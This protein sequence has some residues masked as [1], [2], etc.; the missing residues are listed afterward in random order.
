MLIS[1]II[2]IHN[3]EAFLKRTLLSVLHQTY[4]PLEL[5]LVDNNS[6]DA[7]LRT[8]IYFQAEHSSEDF[9][10]TVAEEKKPGA[11]AARNK[12]LRLAAGKYV[13]F[14]DSD[15]EMLPQRMELIANKIKETSADII[16]SISILKSEDGKCKNKRR[17]YSSSVEKQILAATISTPNFTVKKNIILSI[18]GWN[19]KLFRWQ[20]WEMGIRL[21]MATQNIAWIKGA[22]IDCIYIHSG[23][24]TGDNYHR[25]YNSLMI[26]LKEA[27]QAIINSDYKNKKQAVK[28]IYHQQLWL[29][30]LLFR[31]KQTKLYHECLK[32]LYQS[33]KHSLYTRMIFKLLLAYIKRGGRGT[34]MIAEWLFL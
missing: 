5:I 18:G 1:I 9:I 22:P 20:D 28:L 16:A 29:A 13:S 7:S 19:E 21:L 6:T 17:L 15:D 8:C 27:K 31:E 25:S 33:D 26:A 11:N 10:I 4:R 24:I 14:F 23:G 34:W 3:R 30:G 32:D 12:G 2:P